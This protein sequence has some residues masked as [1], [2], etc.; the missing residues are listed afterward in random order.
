MP[1]A[2]DLVVGGWRLS[3]ILTV[4]TGPYLTPYFPE[5]AGRSLRHR[6]GSGTGNFGNGTGSFDGGHRDQHADWVAGQ[7]VKPV[8]KNRF[9]WT[10]PGAFTCPGDTTWTVGNRRAGRA[11]ASILS[12]TERSR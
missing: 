5:R 8:G 11:R 9:N 2:A 12:R 4:Q 6:L 1:R 7:S 10:N 3:S